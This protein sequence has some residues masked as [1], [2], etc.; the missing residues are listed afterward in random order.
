MF[1]GL[2]MLNGESVLPKYSFL[3]LVSLFFFV[4]EVKNI[5]L[6]FNKYI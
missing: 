3:Y 5:K 2:K 1:S 6:M 4:E